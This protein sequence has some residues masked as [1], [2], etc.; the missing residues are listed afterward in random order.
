M[1]L[2]IDALEL[3]GDQ[4][5]VPVSI[6]K[7]GCVLFPGSPFGCLGNPKDP[8]R[9]PIPRKLNPH[10]RAPTCKR[11]PRE[12]LQ[13]VCGEGSLKFDRSQRIPP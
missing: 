11:Y 3:D 8:D 10:P 1:F 6:L 13:D 4:L 7:Y 2:E 5:D 9:V 12:G